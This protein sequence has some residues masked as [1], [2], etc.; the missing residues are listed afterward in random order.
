MEKW[1]CSTI[2]PYP[3][4]AWPE[5][6]LSWSPCCAA[7]SAPTKE[8][9]PE[10]QSWAHAE[11]SVG[12]AGH[13]ESRRAIKYAGTCPSVHPGRNWPG[14]REARRSKKPR[15]G[16]PVPVLSRTPRS[17]TWRELLFIVWARNT[18]FSAISPFHTH[19]SSPLWDWMLSVT[20][21]AAELSCSANKENVMSVIQRHFG[22]H[23]LQL[24]RSKGA[25]GAISPEHNF[26]RIC[27]F[28]CV[29]KLLRH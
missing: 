3:L 5:L 21:D 24:E 10:N 11:T 29:L 14:R 28:S 2:Q 4:R 7:L 8:C 15:L 17:T 25:L 6:G 23:L 20:C 16:S 27:A 1:G 22:N 19:L 26:S 12:T 9:C 13:T 18:N